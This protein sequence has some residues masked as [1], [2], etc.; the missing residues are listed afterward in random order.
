M[1]NGGSD[2]I[3]MKYIKSWTYFLL[4]NSKDFSGPDM[5]NDYH[6]IIFLKKPSEPLSLAMD[7]SENP[8]RYG[9]I[10]LRKKLQLTS[11]LQLEFNRAE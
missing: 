3:S 1:S 5:Y 8:Q 6:F 9:K 7:R 11:V 10:Q 4:L 2:A